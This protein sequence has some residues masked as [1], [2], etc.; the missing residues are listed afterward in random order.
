MKD[1]CHLSRSVTLTV[2]SLWRSS[3]PASSVPGEQQAPRMLMH[4]IAGLVLRL[5]AGALEIPAVKLSMGPCDS[6]TLAIEA[7]LVSPSASA[8]ALTKVP[9]LVLAD[10][11]LEIEL[12]T[13][14]QSGGAS[15]EESVASWISAHALL[16]IS[17]D[18][19]GHPRANVSLHVKARPSGGGW[20]ARALVRTAAWADASSV[21]VHSLSLAGRP[22]PCDCLPVTLRVGY[23]HAPAPEGAVYAAAQAGDVVALQ[24][25]L[26]AGGSTEEANGV[27]RRVVAPSSQTLTPLPPPPFRI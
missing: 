27:R 8:L 26:D 1:E 2:C 10:R 25:A 9:A 5:P 17:V 13:V 15:V 24:A 18:T 7:R 3:T 20:I 19:P 4:A 6:T 14:G 12:A 11:P 23:N 22:V 16:H 21:T